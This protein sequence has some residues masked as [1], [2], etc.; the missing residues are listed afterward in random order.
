MIK[1][2]GV[3][4]HKIYPGE[5][6]LRNHFYYDYTWNKIYRVISVEYNNGAFIGAYIKNDDNT[7]AWIADHP[8]PDYDYYITYDKLNLFKQ[9][10]INTHKAYTGAEIRYWFFRND[11]D[12]SNKKYYKFWKYVSQSGEDAIDDKFLYELYGKLDNK[13]NYVKCR[14]ERVF[15]H[16][17]NVL[18]NEEIEY[19]K[20]YWEYLKK[21]D[22]TR[23]RKK[24]KEK[25]QE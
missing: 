8:H 11:I 6:L 3:I 5:K 25:Y 17:Q 12:I 2:K 20:K 21:R 10:I 1:Q 9:N 15:E 18:T 24:M 14:V 19:N 22:Q 13:G 4:P 23:F 16:K 7:Y